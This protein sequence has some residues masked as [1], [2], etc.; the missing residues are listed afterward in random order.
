MAK[1]DSPASPTATSVTP[2]PV[3][4]GRK[5]REVDAGLVEGMKEL[6]SNGDWASDGLTHPDKATANKAIADYKR[7]LKDAGVSD[8]LTSRSWED[9]G[10]IRIAL[11]R[12][13][14]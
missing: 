12:K 11:S 9:E 10:G 5:P 13:G 3:R 8:E 4:R 1:N 7:A 14:E 2:P 6:I